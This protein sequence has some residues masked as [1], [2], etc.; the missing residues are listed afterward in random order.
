[1]SIKLKNPECETTVRKL[2]VYICVLFTFPLKTT[3]VASLPLPTQLPLHASG[4]CRPKS[5]WGFNTKRNTHTH[6][7]THLS[8][9]NVLCFLQFLLNA[10]GSFLF[11]TRFLEF[12]L[13]G[14]H[15]HLKKN[16]ITHSGGSPTRGERSRDTSEPVPSV[17]STE[18]P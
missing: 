14:T 11:R 17:A 16:S 10:V 12:T 2:L 7:R 4:H 1:M 9:P 5:L 3:V 15:I 18:T 13:L 6:T 8:W